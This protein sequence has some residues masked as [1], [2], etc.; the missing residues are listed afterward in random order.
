[1]RA[2]EDARAVAV[3]VVEYTATLE[4][5]VSVSCSESG[6]SNV[7]TQGVLVG[8]VAVTPSV[9]TG[10]RMVPQTPCGLRMRW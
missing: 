9:R 4:R 8:G 7:W 2:M 3:A 6:N 10:I 5:Q 1:M